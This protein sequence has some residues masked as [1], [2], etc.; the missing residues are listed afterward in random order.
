[1]RDYD[2]KVLAIINVDDFDPAELGAGA[3]AI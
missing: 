1:L 3:D 2:A